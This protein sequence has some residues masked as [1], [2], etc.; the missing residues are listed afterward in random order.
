M[1]NKGNGKADLTEDRCHFACSNAERAVNYAL[2]A[3]RDVASLTLRFDETAERLQ[4]HITDIHRDL[5]QLIAQ[6]GEQVLSINK[7]LKDTED[8]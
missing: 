6:I 3:Q 1:S 7:K 8:K 5:Y 4:S 2:M